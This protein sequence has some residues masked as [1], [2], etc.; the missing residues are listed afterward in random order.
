MSKERSDR[1]DF[2]D[3]SYQIDPILNGRFLSDLSNSSTGEITPLAS[4]TRCPILHFARLISFMALSIS[5]LSFQ[6]RFSV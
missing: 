4:L 6:G 2:P 3:F 5:V 1:H